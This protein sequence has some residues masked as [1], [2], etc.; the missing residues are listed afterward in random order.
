MKVSI[1]TPS[2]NQAPFIE[3]T[4]KS[5]ANQSG[6]EIEHVVFDGGSTDGTIQILKRYEK[7][8]RWTS[9]K[10]KGQTHAVNKGILS[11]D[12]EIIGWL[13]SDDIYYSDTVSRA[14]RYL[15]SH[16]EIDIVYGMADH[17]DLEDKPFETY[18]TEPW[19][20]NRLKDRCFICQPALFFRRQVVKEHGLLDES[21]IYCM[22]YEYW[23]RLGKSGVRFGYIPEKLAGS[24]MYADNKS[25]GQRLNVSREIN[26]M[27]KKTFGRVPD[28]WL[29][30]YANVLIEQDPKRT[31]SP[32]WSAVKLLLLIIYS[33]WLWNGMISSNMIKVLIQSVWG[34]LWKRVTP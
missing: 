6:V 2:Y 10:D 7:S 8:V 15:D 31:K 26:D 9:E 23:L 16:P 19:N 27:L 32:H 20:F 29:L 30:N 12:G 33:S 3:R 4:L 5:V 34:P 13:N 28:S 24:R 1:I 22:D 21:L 11:T 25:L 17:I 14:V 18:P